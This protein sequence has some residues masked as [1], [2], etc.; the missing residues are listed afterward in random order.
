MDPTI[1]LIVK[2]LSIRLGWI[3]VYEV[4][5]GHY[6]MSTWLKSH[7]LGGLKSFWEGVPFK[8]VLF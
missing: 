6:P 5:F 3:G 2:I 7:D 4:R 8:T 1:L